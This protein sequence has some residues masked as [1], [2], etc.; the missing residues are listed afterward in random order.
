MPIGAEAG[1][2]A[3]AV[4]TG[5]IQAPVAK[6]ARLGTLEIQIP[7]VGPANVPLIAA[8]EIASAGFIGRLKGAAFR[9]G[10]EAWNAARN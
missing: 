6:G 5:P 1:V 8:E 10:G 3:E 4:F 2:T 7:G 9:L